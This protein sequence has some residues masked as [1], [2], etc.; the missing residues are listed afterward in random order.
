MIGPLSHT[1]LYTPE[2]FRAHGLTGATLCEWTVC[3]EYNGPSIEDDGC[4]TSPA[5]DAP[6]CIHVDAL[7]G[8]TSLMEWM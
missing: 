6:T 5:P 7:T 4:V 1:R 2:W 8:E 3:F